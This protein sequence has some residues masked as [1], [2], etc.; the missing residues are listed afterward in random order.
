MPVTDQEELKSLWDSATSYQEELRNL[1]EESAPAK[2]EG[3]L[4]GIGKA[5]VQGAT[6]FPKA[7]WGA[8]AALEDL[9]YKGFGGKDEYKDL[10]AGGFAKRQYEGVKDIEKRFQPQQEGVKRHITDAV[11]TMAQMA[12]SFAGT[13]GMGTLPAMAG[14]AGIEK[15]LETRKEGYS[16]PKSASAGVS[17]GATEYL[18]ELIPIKILS[19]PGLSFM[20]RLAG[21]LIADVPGE[22]VATISEMKA[23]DEGI[24]GKSYT[25]EQ[26]TRALIDTAITSGLVTLGAT[27]AVQP[28]KGKAPTKAEMDIGLDFSKAEEA[29]TKAEAETKKETIPNQEELK[30]LWENATPIVEPTVETIIPK[31]E[32]IFLTPKEQS[33]RID[34]L[35]EDIIRKEFKPVKVAQKL[36][37]EMTPEEQSSKLSMDIRK[38]F[39]GEETKGQEAQESLS[40]EGQETSPDIQGLP[41]VISG[42]NN[43]VL[44]N[45]K[46]KNKQTADWIKNY[47]DN[48]SSI[49]AR[50]NITQTTGIT[51]KGQAQI[52]NM[53]SGVE[54]EFINQSTGI[55]STQVL[56]GDPNAIIPSID[57]Y[58]NEISKIKEQRKVLIGEAPIAPAQIQPAAA[59]ETPEKLE[60][61]QNVYQ[62]IKDEVGSKIKTEQSFYDHFGKEEAREIIRRNLGMFSKS[63]GLP[64]DEI[65]DSLNITTDEL[66]DKMR[67]ALSKKE[68]AE[69]VSKELTREEF[70]KSEALKGHPIVTV[71]N[72][73]LKVGDKFKILGEQYT[74]KEKDA[75]GNFLIEDGDKYI[76]DE[77]DKIPQPDE[78]S[79]I[80]GKIKYSQPKL[81]EGEKVDIKPQMETEAQGQG[82]LFETAPITTLETFG[83]QSIYEKLE[84]FV[85]SGKTREG[86]DSVV[87]LAN[88]VYTG[89]GFKTFVHDMKLALGNLWQHYSGMIP[90]V[91]RSIN[92]KTQARVNQVLAYEVAE[93]ENLTDEQLKNIGMTEADIAVLK[94]HKSQHKKFRPLSE[95][96]NPTVR[97]FIEFWSPLATL[98]D[99][100]KYQIERY[101]AFGD[102]ARIEKLTSRVVEKTRGF[103]DETNNKLFKYLDGDLSLEGLPQEVRQYA[104]TLQGMNRRIGQMLV[105]RG[106]ITQKAWEAHKNEYIRYVYLKYMLEDDDIPTT[107]GKIDKAAL[108]G[109]MDPIIKSKIAGKEY[110]DKNIYEGLLKV[111]GAL[112][113]KH[114]RVMKAG[115][116]KLG[117]ASVGGQT[118]TQFATELSVLAHEIGH[119][120]DFKYG[121][122]DKI[123]RNAEGIGARGKITKTASAKKRGTIQDELRALADLTWE[124]IEA[125]PYYKQKVRKQPEKMAHML[126]AYIHAPD[127]FK[128][129]SP[130]VYQE[131]DSFIGSTPILQELS[132]L[133]QGLALKELQQTA[134]QVMSAS[135]KIYSANNLTLEQAQAKQ[136]EVQKRVDK[137]RKAAGLVEDV[138]VA[139]PISISIALQNVVAYDKLSKIADNS[140]WVWQP[141]VIDIEGKKWGIGALK[142]E[143]DKQAK[144]VADN[145]D[146]VEIRERYDTLNSAFKTAREESGNEPSDFLQLPTSPSYGNLSGMFVRKPIYRDLV[147]IFSGFQNKNVITKT[148][149]TI[150]KIE[151]EGMALFKIFKTAFNIPTYFRNIISNMIQLNMS[152]IPVYDVPGYAIKG[153]ES[154]IKKDANYTKA[155]RSGLFKTNFIES[156]IREIYETFKKMNSNSWFD[157]VHQAAK[158]GKYYGKID[159]VFKM[160]KYMEQIENGVSSEESIIQA[161][162]WGMDYSTAHPSIKYLR[163]H[164]MPFA[165]Y[166]YK[167]TSLMAETMVKR[168]WI[169]AKYLAIPSLMTA[170]AK[171]TLDLSDDDWEKLRKRLP[172]FIR[173]SNSMAVLPWKSKTGDLQWINLEWYFPGQMWLALSRDIQNKDYWEISRD[174]G[175]ANPFADVY[176]MMQ[177]A[178]GKGIPKDPYTGKDIYNRL[179]SGTEKAL[180]TTEWVYNKWMPQ[181]LTRFGTAGKIAEIGKEDKYGQVSTVGGAVGSLFGV[182]V[183]S[184]TEKQVVIE[185]MAR[186]KE[187]TSSLYRKLQETKDETKREAVIKKY[188]QELEKIIKGE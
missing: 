138:S 67:N 57:N 45:L 141:S 1:W 47:P 155:F 66:A 92:Q 30:T 21:G 14:G 115:R 53:G 156:E 111:A 132:R 170:L 159:D 163:R 145:P 43:Q 76:V 33:Q 150:I 128:E 49:T 105:K 70:E 8:G 69:K 160:A 81:L 131:F 80:K 84:S 68:Q 25:P 166:S 48:I 99:S 167:I 96:Q 129:V 114:E 158:L 117:Y 181:M 74:V 135:G 10:A 118:V 2:K 17:T 16:I 126:E 177:S 38:Q 12:S 65:A 36:F 110:V 123:V 59:I 139:E 104:M 64:M 98:P 46:E 22:L 116:G 71:G 90:K 83:F 124:G 39:L 27:G 9:A 120:L 86:Y 164:L 62:Q 89:S 28:F 121:L 161:Q 165:S 31:E 175:I 97:R 180:K 136:L 113:I 94:K 184:P 95:L 108:K 151:T 23:V 5:A 75:E 52:A 187:L 112:R 56:F 79:I 143:V 107:G 179:D 183:I 78:G 140:D 173:K 162:K 149:N 172:M 11:R 152:G 157:I 146:S 93:G 119:Q 85:K 40:L 154:I 147:P 41:L 61:S 51:N 18:T 50:D 130:T 4:K 63:S 29:E 109:R 186:E 153:L 148:L 100:I 77:F 171:D 178:R 185:K 20:K 60:V 13:A 6:A 133:K 44:H 188:Q 42:L 72:L 137:Y 34:A 82:K 37:S 103:D 176:A 174:I 55:K 142:L 88:R 168:P 101:K 54:V 35:N 169:I 102:V 127:R 134:Y 122:W 32:T 144:L 87:E 7:F 106:L 182:N 15:Y 19:K 91:W 73:D 24:L 3:F 58:L 26:Y 125:S